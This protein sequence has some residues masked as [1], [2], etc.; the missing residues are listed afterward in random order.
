MFR[1]PWKLSRHWACSMCAV[2]WER[3]SWAVASQTSQFGLA[4]AVFSHSGLT[5]YLF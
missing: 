4:Q 1:S 5:S 2:M 3:Q